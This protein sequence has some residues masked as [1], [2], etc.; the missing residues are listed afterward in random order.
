MVARSLRGNAKGVAL[1]NCTT[2][3]RQKSNGLF[4]EFHN[5]VAQ[6]SPSSNNIA[7]VELYLPT[8]SG[9]FL[10]LLGIASFPI[11]DLKRRIVHGEKD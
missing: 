4:I 5:M 11:T 7:I 10:N 6:S 1:P 2:K 9:M 8:I 3:N